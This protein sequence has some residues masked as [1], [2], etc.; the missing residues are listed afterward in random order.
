VADF[1]SMYELFRVNHLALIYEPS[2]PATT[3]GSLIQWIDP[4]PT[5]E[6]L[7]EVGTVDPRLVSKAATSPMSCMNTCWTMGYI[8]YAQRKDQTDFYVN[9]GFGPADS[10]PRLVS[11]GTY[12]IMAPGADLAV[13]TVL[14]NVLVSYD[15]EFITPQIEDTLPEGNGQATSTTGVAAD[16][17]YGAVLSDETTLDIELDYDGTYT[18]LKFPANIQVAPTLEPRFLMVLEVVGTGLAA[19]GFTQTRSEMTNISSQTAT[20]AG[21]TLCMGRWITSV[22]SG[23]LAPKVR[24]S[25]SSD[26]TITAVSLFVTSWTPQGISSSRPT[27]PKLESKIEELQDRLDAITSAFEK[28]SEAEEEDSRESRKI[29]KKLDILSGA[30]PSP[31]PS[32]PQRK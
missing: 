9:E 28:V 27:L 14:G 8:K 30:L 19:G 32:T 1:A 17:L 31:S 13:N 15:I 2:C 11:P 20:N 3:A 4:D 10:D 7:V 26:T 24:F 23:Q 22:A 12:F 5:D 18:W 16:L 25:I 29:K 6:A 21:G